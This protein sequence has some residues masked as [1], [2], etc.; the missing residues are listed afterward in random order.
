MNKLG[1]FFVRVSVGL[2]LHSATLDYVIKCMR[3]MSHEENREL[4][5]AII[6]RKEPKEIDQCYAS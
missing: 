1:T 6:S 2:R 5:S 3:G 4:G